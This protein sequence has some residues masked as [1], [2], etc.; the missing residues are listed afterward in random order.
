MLR[1]GQLTRWPENQPH[2]VHLGEENNGGE[3]IAGQVPVPAIQVGLKLVRPADTQ[4]G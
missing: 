3:D 1:V 4:E 2:T